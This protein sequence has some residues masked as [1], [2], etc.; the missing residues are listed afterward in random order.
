VGADESSQQQ[1]LQDLEEHQTKVSRPLAGIEVLQLAG[2]RNTSITAI[3]H[4]GDLCGIIYIATQL[5]ED[6][7]HI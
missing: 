2:Y 6:P 3:N 5:K 4:F 1:S 7:K